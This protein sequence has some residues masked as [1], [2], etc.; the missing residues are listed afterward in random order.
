VGP[1][2]DEMKNVS[3]G[4]IGNLPDTVELPWSYFE[5]RGCFL[6]CRGPLVISAQ[7]AWGFFVR[8]LT[9]SHDIAGWPSLGPVIPYGVTVES[10]AWIGSFSLLT[11]CSIGAGSIVA[12]GT[13]VRGQTVAPGIMVAGNPARIVARWTGERWD[14]LSKEASGFCRELE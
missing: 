13:V 3:T 4:C 6:D 1:G 2:E 7:S 5:S 10:G 8:V 12:A 11:G 14:Y 9:E